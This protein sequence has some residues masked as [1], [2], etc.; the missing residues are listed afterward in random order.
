MVEWSLVSS[1]SGAWFCQ[2][3]YKH[4]TL[5]WF[6][7]LAQDLLNEKEKLWAAEREKLVSELREKDALGLQEQTA[8]EV[9]F[10]TYTMEV[11]HDD[12]FIFLYESANDIRGM[13]S[14]AFTKHRWCVLLYDWA[15]G[16]RSQ[17]STGVIIVCYFI[18]LFISLFC[19]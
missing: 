2:S 8:T 6:L 15:C 1:G 19:Y 4:L 3:C 12:D 10:L 9:C 11:S 7:S 17:G 18:S 13:Q 5:C 14:L 16:Y